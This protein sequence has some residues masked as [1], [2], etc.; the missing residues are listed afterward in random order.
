M[1][2][3]VLSV[4][5]VPAAD[6]TGARALLEFCEKCRDMGTV[7]CFS[8]VQNPVRETLMRT[9]VEE[10]VGA[11]RFFWS[12]EEALDAVVPLCQEECEK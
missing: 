2:A 7:V 9:G 4:R 11:E 1:G 8:G 10:L 12:A 3:V 5:G 6:S